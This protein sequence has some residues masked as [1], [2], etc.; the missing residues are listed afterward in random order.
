MQNRRRPFNKKGYNLLSE[1]QNI[2][3]YVNSGTNVKVG[4]I[5]GIFPFQST[6]MDKEG[7]FND[8]Y[9]EANTHYD[10]QITSKKQHD[11]DLGCRL[12]KDSTNYIAVFCNMKE[13]IIE[14][15]DFEIYKTI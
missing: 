14:D 15:E 9:I 8:S 12:W 13:P 10:L 3:I 11:Y 1:E 2:V 6:T 7:F 5:N 4:T